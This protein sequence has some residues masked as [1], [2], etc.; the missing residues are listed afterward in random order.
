MVGSVTRALLAV[1]RAAARR[2]TAEA[3]FRAKI[4][5]A[6]KATVLPAAKEDSVAATAAVTAAAIRAATAAADTNSSR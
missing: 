2:E 4:V 1:Q 3:D 6:R 5:A